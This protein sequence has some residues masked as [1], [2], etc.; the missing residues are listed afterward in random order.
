MDEE[1]SEVV[2]LEEGEKDSECEHNVE[3]KEETG[4]GGCS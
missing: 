3:L 1:G 2:E 4:E